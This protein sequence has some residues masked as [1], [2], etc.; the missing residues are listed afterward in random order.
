VTCAIRTTA[1][2]RKRIVGREA[3]ALATMLQVQAGFGRPHLHAGVSI[4][5]LAP[6]IF[7]CRTDLKM[8]LVFI[9]EKGALTFDFAGNHDE[10]QNYLRGQR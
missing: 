1:R 4:R 7:E 5:K 6:D 2:F 8:R 9:A 10:V 3:D